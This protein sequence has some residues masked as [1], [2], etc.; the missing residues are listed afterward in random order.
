MW[1]TFL[2]KRFSAA[3]YLMDKVGKAPKDRL[4]RRDVG[5]SD[6]AVTSFLGCCWDLLQTLMEADVSRDEMQVPV[7]DTEDAWLTVEGPVSIVELALDQKHIHYPLVVHHSVLG[8][9]LYAV[10]RFSLKTV[11]PLSLFD[12]KGKNAFFKDL[13]SIQLLPSGEMDP[14]FISVRQ[15]FLLK[16]VSAAVQARHTV[17]KDRDSTEEAATAP[18][19]KD[20]D[21]PVLA[22]DLA[23]H[24]QVNEDVVRRHY[25]G[26]LYNYGA[27]HLGEEVT[28]S[29]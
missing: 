10:M 5:M 14:N 27:D 18:F 15:Q 4:C 11:K 24:L 19:G 13:T 20:Q 23:H 22:V 2:V 8:A 7:L 17:A 6:T 29:L 9:I 26:E 3:T 1:N 21:W 12:S 28:N 25:V 16:V